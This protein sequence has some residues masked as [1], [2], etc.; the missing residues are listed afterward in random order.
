M[1]GK[2][3]QKLMDASGFTPVQLSKLLEIHERT[4][5]RYISGQTPITKVIALAINYVCLGL[6]LKQKEES[7]DDGKS[8]L[9]H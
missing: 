4:V 3:L 1:T 2:Q 6:T 9:P 7:S 5:Y 8:S